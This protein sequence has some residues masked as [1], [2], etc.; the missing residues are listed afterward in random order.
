MAIFIRVL[1]LVIPRDDIPPRRGGQEREDAFAF[2]A[3]M[4]PSGWGDVAVRRQGGVPR[5]VSFLGL[6]L[7]LA[8]FLLSPAVARAEDAPAV[9]RAPDSFSITFGIPSPPASAPYSIRPDFPTLTARQVWSAAVSAAVKVLPWPRR[10]PPAVLSVDWL[11]ALPPSAGARDDALGESHGSHVSIRRA[12]DD[13]LRD[14][15]R[16][17]HECAHFLFAARYGA[18]FPLWIDEGLAQLVG[19]RAAEAFARPQHLSVRRTPPP[20][21]INAAF[22]LP[23]LVAL[24]EYPADPDAVAAFYWQSAALV[25]ALHARLGPDAFDAFLSALA[26]QTPP[27]SDWTAPLRSICYFNDADFAWLATRIL[28]SPPPSPHDSAPWAL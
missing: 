25:R 22:T 9:E 27:A 21:W 11:P 18:D 2:R 26:A 17:G 28:P 7:F 16:A 14:A 24:T 13:P 23:E 12:T 20:G 5:R 1:P 10:K 3:P 19:Y 8:F 6:S 4:P 15:F